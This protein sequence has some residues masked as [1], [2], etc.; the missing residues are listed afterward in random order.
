M[1]DNVCQIRVVRKKPTAS[2]RITVR[3]PKRTKEKLERI[4]NKLAPP[5]TRATPAAAIRNLIEE[6]NA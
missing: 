5:G 1:S 2:E 3:L 4:A 6:K